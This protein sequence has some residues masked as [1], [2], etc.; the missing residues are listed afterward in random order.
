M[1]VARAQRIAPS[2]ALSLAVR[3]AVFE[4]ELAARS[5]GPHLAVTAALARSTLKSLMADAEREGPVRDAELHDAT[6]AHWLELDRPAGYFTVH[7]V[8][9]LDDKADAAKRAAAVEIAAAIRRAVEP[10]GAIAASTTRPKKASPRA[11][12]EDAVVAPFKLAA[13]SVAHPGFEVVIEELPP[14]T[15]DARVLTPEGSQFDPDFARA[16]AALTER[17]QL[18]PATTSAF[19]VHVIMLLEKTPEH[20][21]SKEERL[22]LLTPEIMTLRARRLEQTLLDPSR[23][24]IEVALSVD[25]LL[26]LVR[27]EP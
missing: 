14:V 3:D 18:A 24:N 27:V 19:G 2:D 23:K 26:A 1:R 17:G 15:A 11:R 10:V 20:V 7:A 6:A 25:A 13:G 9:R 22:S 4:N 5:T 8:V 12:V 21:V 16:A